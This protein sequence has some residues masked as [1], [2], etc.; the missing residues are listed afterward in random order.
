MCD[1][2]SNSLPDATYRSLNT[3]PGSYLQN[4]TTNTL[5][6]TKGIVLHTGTTALWRE[7]TALENKKLSRNDYVQV[8]PP[9]VT[10]MRLRLHRR[11]CVYIAGWRESIAIH[12]DSMWLCLHLSDRCLE[13]FI[14]IISS[15]ILTRHVYSLSV[16]ICF[17]VFF[18]S[19]DHFVFVLSLFIICYLFV[20]FFNLLVDSYATYS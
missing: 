6:R 9:Q 7:T 15:A 10:H 3:I 16:C 17:I 19:V 12:R 8:S 1:S 13:T 14:L 18:I 11:A 5:S 20:I 2:T 4:S